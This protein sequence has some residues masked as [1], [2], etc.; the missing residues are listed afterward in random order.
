MGAGGTPLPL[1]RLNWC[2]ENRPRLDEKRRVCA[3]ALRAR[4]AAYFQI[5]GFRII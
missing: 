5:K 4:L 1:L 3:W 2:Q